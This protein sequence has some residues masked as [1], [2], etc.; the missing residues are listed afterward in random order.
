MRAGL[1]RDYVTIQRNTP[2]QGLSGEEIDNWSNLSNT[3]AYIRGT[4]GEENINALQMRI[5]YQ[6]IVHTDRVL[7]GARIFDIVS[8]T[9]AEGMQRNLVVELREDTSS[10]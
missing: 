3:W 7:F 9:D 6:D 2:T 1:M 4:G 10:G 8:V 5:R